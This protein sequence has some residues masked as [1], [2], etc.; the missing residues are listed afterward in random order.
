[1]RIMLLLLMIG[2][3]LVPVKSPQHIVQ[4]RKEVISKNSS[5]FKECDQKNKINS[6]HFNCKL[7][8]NKPDR[9]WFP[10]RFA[11]IS[12]ENSKCFTVKKVENLA[13]GEVH[14]IQQKLIKLKFPSVVK[15]STEQEY[16]ETELKL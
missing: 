12:L 9:Y 2:C 8:E 16:V 13:N 11:Y 3:D 10:E 4:M 6:V 5:E 15:K 7:T 14:C 1:M